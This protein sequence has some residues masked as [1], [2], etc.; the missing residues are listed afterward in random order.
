MSGLELD[1]I[2]SLLAIWQKKIL[3]EDRTAK[4]VL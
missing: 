2:K 1:H 4:H 3:L